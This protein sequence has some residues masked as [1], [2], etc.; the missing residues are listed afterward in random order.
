MDVT[1]AI[2]TKMV[3]PSHVPTYSAFKRNL[4][5]VL[6]AKQEPHVIWVMVMV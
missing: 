2:V 4:Q 5:S 6:S 1:P 3:W